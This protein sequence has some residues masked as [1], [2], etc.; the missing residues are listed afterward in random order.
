MRKQLS[1]RLAVAA[2][3]LGRQS[4]RPELMAPADQFL[5]SAGGDVYAPLGEGGFVLRNIVLRLRWKHRLA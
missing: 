5:L 1:G 3:H 4:D 2:S